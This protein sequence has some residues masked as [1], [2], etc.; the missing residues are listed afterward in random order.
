MDGPCEEIVLTVNGMNYCAFCIL[1]A[2]C[3]RI[4]ESF[5][6]EIFV[7]DYFFVD[8]VRKIHVRN[9]VLF[10]FD[11]SDV[12]RS[13]VLVLTI[14]FFNEILHSSFKLGKEG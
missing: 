8:T 5:F 12:T 7:S 1:R 2:A 3:G 14:F 11:C 10:I 6:R 9:S 4:F 13:Q